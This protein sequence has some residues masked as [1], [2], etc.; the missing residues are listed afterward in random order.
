MPECICWSALFS[1]IKAKKNVTHSVSLLCEM[2]YQTEVEMKN[3]KVEVPL[4]EILNSVDSV[5]QIEIFSLSGTLVLSNG[6]VFGSSYFALIGTLSSRIELK[7]FNNN[8]YSA[9]AW[10]AHCML[11]FETNDIIK[12]QRNRLTTYYIHYM[13]YSHSVYCNWIETK[14]T[15]KI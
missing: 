15:N 12:D 3:F 9:Y 13:P 6:C 11:M 1:L 8:A 4:N 14:R 10:A 7:I 2:S 5:K